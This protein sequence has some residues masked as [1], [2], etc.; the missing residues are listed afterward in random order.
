[1]ASRQNAPSYH[2]RG[3]PILVE[4][5]VPLAY[6]KVLEGAVVRVAL[7]GPDKNGPDVLNV[8]T[9]PSGQSATL[10]RFSV[11]EDTT[12]G[13][14]T[15]EIRIGE[16]AF[17]VSVE[18]EARPHLQMSP[19]RFTFMAAPGA[20]ITTA[21]T[22]LN[23]GNVPVQISEAG[24]FGLFDVQGFDRAIGE[25]FRAD[26]KGAT[27]EA[28]R[29]VDRIFSLVA[30]EHGGLVRVQFRDGAGTIKPGEFR[31]LNALVRMPDGI[32]P[33]HAYSGMWPVANLRIAVR[34]EVVE[35]T[36]SKEVQ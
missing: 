26:E 3:A 34:V 20:Q 4:G 9:V 17:P 28:A 8:Q 14:Y 19:S 30:Q 31:T 23:S 25:T 24:G 15:G 7:T 10:V 36:G 21:M 18:I 32:K 16:T 5:L 13:G 35:R 6:Q 27:S 22:A 33:G 2:F 29:P 12:A 11:P 1:M